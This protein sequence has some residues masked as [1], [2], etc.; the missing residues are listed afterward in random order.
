MRYLQPLAH[1]CSAHLSFLHTRRWEGVNHYMLPSSAEEGS[2]SD[3]AY[4]RPHC[5]VLDVCVC[6]C[7]C[8]YGC[9]SVCV[10][11]CVLTWTSSLTFP[12]VSHHVYCSLTAVCII[13]SLLRSSGCRCQASFAVATRLRTSHDR[14]SSCAQCS[15]V[16]TQNRRHWR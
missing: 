13:L 15:V 1:T 10:C 14:R 2:I 11:I 7:M 6:V 9:V 12:I 8:E 5:S 16:G 3:D 4:D